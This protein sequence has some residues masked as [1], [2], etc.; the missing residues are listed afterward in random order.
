MGDTSLSRC[1]YLKPKAYDRCE[2]RKKFQSV[3]K[4]ISIKSEGVKRR[5]KCPKG[6][7]IYE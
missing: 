7:A 4:R 3:S 5:L 2:G 6:W 1:G